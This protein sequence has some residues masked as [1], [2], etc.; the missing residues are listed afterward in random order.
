MARTSIKPED[1]TPVQSQNTAVVPRT[2]PV[3]DGYDPSQYDDTTRDVTIPVLGLIGGIGPLAKKFMN[4]GGQF[5]LGDVLLPATVQ[6]IP[7]AL[8]KFVSETYR[9]GRELKYDDKD[10]TPKIWP[11][12][13]AAYKDGGYRI[14]FEGLYPN[15]IEERGRIGYLVRKPDELTGAEAAEFNHT[16][17]DG[18][19]YA[20][21]KCT[22]RRG[23]FR[24]TWRRIFDNSVKRANAAGISTKGL[25]HAELFNAA[26]GWDST[27]TLSGEY[28]DGKKN[29]WWEPR[30]SRGAALTPEVFAW[31]T[32]EFGTLRA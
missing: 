31:V 21:A 1:E 26:K 20:V 4:K 23:G 25:G 8:V 27:W 13:E 17:P 12:A 11:S 10:I 5:A 9:E 7:V 30:A 14:D 16:A 22:Y 29:S 32:D 28:I 19:K 6:A 24:E 2:P 3:D 15:R 18:T